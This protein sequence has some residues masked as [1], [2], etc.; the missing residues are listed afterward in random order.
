MNYCGKCGHKLDLNTGLCPKCNKKQLKAMEKNTKG[1]KGVNKLFFII[2]IAVVILSLII[3]ILIF[4]GNMNREGN[5]LLSDAD[6]MKMEI[7]SCSYDDVT[8]KNGEL[9]VKSQ[10]VITADPKYQY[11]DIEK[12]V[13]EDNGIIVGY[14]EFT[15]DY[16]IEYPDSSYEKLDNIKNRLESELD[17]SEIML[18]RVS[19]RTEETDKTP[20]KEFQPEDNNGNWWRDAINLSQLEEDNYTFKEVKVGVYDTLFDTDNED[21]KYALKS[22]DIWYNDSHI[23]E[24]TDGGTHGTNVLGF[25]AAKKDNEYGIQGVANNVKVYGYAYRGF[26]PSYNPVS[27]MEEKYWNA[28]MLAKGVRVIN[29]SAGNGELLVGAQT[30]NTKAIYALQQVSSSLSTF[31]KKYIDAGYEFIIVKSAGNENGYTWIRC[32]ESKD[33]PYGVKVYNEETDGDLTRYQQI[34]NEVFDAKYDIWGAIEDNS[35]RKRIIIVGSSSEENTRAFHSV[36]GER[37]DIY[38]PGERLRELTSDTPSYGTSYAAPMVAGSVAL[39]W[40]VNSD[41]PA[42]RIKYLLVATASQPI[43]DENYLVSTDTGNTKMFKCLLDINNAVDRAKEYA[44]NS[45]TTENTSSYLMGIVKTY[46][47][48]KIEY[49]KENCIVTIYK[50]NSDETLYKELTTDEYGEFETD[51]E[52]GSYILVAKTPDD[53]YI[54]DR[55]VFSVKPKDAVYLNYIYMYPVMKGDIS[56]TDFKCD[57][58]LVEYDNVIYYVDRDG[59]WKNTGNS[60]NELLYDCK[61]TNIATN[62]EIIYYSVFN[63]DQTG[64]SSAAGSDLTWHQFDLYSY[65]LRSKLNTKIT[66]FNE[67]GQPICAYNGKIYYTD[68]PDDYSGHNV[69]L[70]QNLYAYDMQSDKKELICEG[71]GKLLIYHDKIFFRDKVVTMDVGNAQIYCLNLPDGNIKQITR[72]GVLDFSI[73]EDSLFYTVMNYN[74]YTGTNNKP[75]TKVNCKVYQYNI[76][77]GT[78][79]AIFDEESDHINIQH[80]DNNYIYYTYDYPYYNYRLNLETGE[81]SSFN[82]QRWSDTTIHQVYKTDDSALYYHAAYFYFYE[83][84]DSEKSPHKIKDGYGNA[85]RLL[86]IKNGSLFAVYDDSDADYYFYRIARFDFKHEH[87]EGE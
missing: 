19:Y 40:G 34:N 42:E 48:G 29:I 17:N 59:L 39:M 79:T 11:S 60:E 85:E 22:D 57:K 54:S 31:Y 27:I 25:L 49:N 45:S 81:K 52:T 53:A 33:N 70:A 67:C 14:L 24:V 7:K 38:A 72:D 58:Y 36:S 65:D 13:S 3:F 9:Y 2:P 87:E 30:G 62:G 47:E 63:K 73:S 4:F 46:D 75:Y 23:I 16:Q 37:V 51:I 35:V 84:M 80:V 41:I 5:S 44:S 56:N 55:Y 10:L 12:V 26:T 69:G 76:L 64:Y 6:H 43:E 20:I 61:A 32:S 1:K 18:N 71:A 21:L 15:N 86:L 8:Y 83:L 77:D 78:E 66:S 50:N 74:T 28:K 68:Y 82:S